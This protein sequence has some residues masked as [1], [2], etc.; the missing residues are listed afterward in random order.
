MKVLISLTIIILLP[1][2]IKI[3]WVICQ[4]YGNGNFAKEKKELIRR[5]N[6][7]ISKV[8]TSP[9]QVLSTSPACIGPQ[10]QG[11]WAIYSCSMTCK[12]L[13]NIATIYPEFRE[14]A[15]KH[16]PSIINIALSD[17]IRAYDTRRWG[18]DALDGIDGNKSHLSYYSHVAWMIGEF[19]RTGGDGRFDK[20]YHSFCE[21]MNRRIT[22]SPILNL[23]TYPYESIYIPD[24]L[25]A[26]VALSDY[27]KLHNGRYQ[28]TVDAWIH[29]AK[30][31][32][33]D[34]QTGLLTSY[35]S[36]DGTCS[37]EIRGSYSALNTYY[38]S[39]IDTAFA[40][41]QYQH[42][43]KHFL[44]TSPAVGIKEYRDRTCWF[45]FDV[46]AGP[47][48]LNLSA[49]ATAFAIGCATS[50]NDKELRNQLLRTAE[51]AG[52]TFTWGNKSHYLLA[53]PVLVGEAITL[54]LRTSSSRFR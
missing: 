40:S 14:T 1:L 47:I 13:A 32:W 36:E 22:D 3:F 4:T 11:E 38:L 33:M 46:D 42:L 35:L 27:A 20:I 51:I 5:A 54:A 48:I 44:Q 31:E 17:T 12:A 30:S 39:L 52:T 50:L 26:I 7:L 41:E 24:M 29:K 2:V 45:A 43:K 9:Q 6:Y 53:Q 49:S 23:P 18:E 19:K 16:I 28:E 8:D 15:I 37:S 34:P 21:A 25:V 10:F